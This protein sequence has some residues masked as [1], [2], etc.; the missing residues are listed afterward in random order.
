[1]SISA[2][3]SFRDHMAPCDFVIVD[4]FIDRTFARE[5]TF[6]DESVVA[7]VSVAHPKCG[8]LSDLV[9]RLQR[10]FR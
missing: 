10:E 4:Q 7:H 6:F 8:G 1:M 9:M 5:K 2:C 3:G